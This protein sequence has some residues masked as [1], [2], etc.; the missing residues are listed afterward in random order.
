MDMYQK[1]KIRKEKGL[2]DFFL[3]SIFRNL[4]KNWKNGI[5]TRKYKKYKGM[6]HMKIR[7]KVSLNG[8]KNK[9]NRIIELNDEMTMK[10]FCEYIII[11][12]NG[13]CKHLY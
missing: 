3:Q 5:K 10:L 12:M 8:L 2:K 7:A 1:R 6:K 4:M 11:S 9:V 13:N